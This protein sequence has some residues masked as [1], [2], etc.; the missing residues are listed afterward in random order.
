M[1]KE[2]ARTDDQTIDKDAAD[3]RRNTGKNIGSEANELRKP[4]TSRIFSQIDTTTHTDGDGNQGS[5]QAD[6]KSTDDGITNT[7]SIQARSRGELSEE[8]QADQGTTFDQHIHQHEHQGK[9]TDRCKRSS[10]HSEQKAPAIASKRG[11]KTKR[12]PLKA[13]MSF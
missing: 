11:I 9:H 7:T 5:N 4:A 10:Q 2:K 12:R 8:A 13:R 3:N 6:H 1:V